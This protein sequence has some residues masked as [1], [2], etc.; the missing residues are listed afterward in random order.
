MPQHVQ[1]WFP[2]M[3]QIAWCVKISSPKNENTVT[4]NL[5]LC[6]FLHVTQAETIII[7]F[8]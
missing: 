4:I 8:V 2:Y 3:T 6:V 7:V 5:A 1:D